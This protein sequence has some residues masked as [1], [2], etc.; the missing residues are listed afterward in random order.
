MKLLL[1]VYIFSLRHVFLRNSFKSYI[2]FDNHILIVLS[3]V[4]INS[5]QNRIYFLKNFN[6]FIISAVL[7]LR[8]CVWVCFS[9]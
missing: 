1:K 4:L 5:L 7:G 6:S 8:S 2:T 3:W 9:V